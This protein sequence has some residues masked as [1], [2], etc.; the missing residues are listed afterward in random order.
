MNTQNNSHNC[1]YVQN[2]NTTK[3]KKEFYISSADEK[4]RM[5]PPVGKQDGMPTKDPILSKMDTHGELDFQQI[6]DW[7]ADD[8]DTTTTRLPHPGLLA[9]YRRRHWPQAITGVLPQKVVDTYERVKQHGVPNCLGAR[10]IVESSL[11][12]EAWE[13]YLTKIVENKTLLDFIKFGF[14]LGYLGP[15]TDTSELDNHSSAT[16]FPTHICKYINTELKWGSL[17]GPLGK[18]PFTWTHVSPMMTRPKSEE[19]KRRIIL[20][21]SYPKDR[22]VNAFIKKKTALGLTFSHVLPSV[23]NLTKDIRSYGKGC[24]LSCIDVK[25]AYK[26]FISCPLSWPL[27]ACTWEGS[28]YL[29]TSM[30]FGARVSSTHMQNVADHLTQIVQKEGHKSYMYLDDWIQVSETKQGSQAAYD[31]ARSLLEELGLPE[32]TEKTQ[33]PTTQ[34]KWLGIDI[35]TEK[36]EISIPS[37]KT[38]EILELV[39]Q[40]RERKSITVKRLQSL[41]GKLQHISKCVAPGRLFVNRLLEKL[42]SSTGQ[43]VR[44]DHEARKDLDWY[45]SFL[46]EWNGISIISTGV[47][48]MEI[49]ADACPE[50]IGASDYDRAYAAAVPASVKGRHISAIESI[51]VLIAAKTFINETHSGGVIRIRC[52]NSAA[53]EV[54]RTGK[55]RDPSLLATAREIWR[56]QA[57]LSVK[58]LFVHTPGKEMELADKLSRSVLSQKHKNNADEI[59]SVYSLKMCDPD[60][61]SLNCDIVSSHYRP[62][63]GM[64]H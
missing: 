17:I 38:N 7:C 29:D 15:V 2:K 52:D 18:I 44:L 11:N 23:D 16:N 27:L 64:A 60:L 59:I 35:D 33:P 40:A 31:R 42:R 53:V 34:L 58:I 10:V 14:D 46:K 12:L 41:L 3:H 48:V 9:A 21:L 45:I 57:E 24:Y 43:H 4:T 56:I 8:K 54:Y 25:R 49:V 5:C 63:A 36:M 51:N 22:S 47:I 1:T 32:A 62:S 55:G 61:S 39:Q 19:D 37:A 13:Y 26:N 50:G 20:D 28:Y 6:R 30:P